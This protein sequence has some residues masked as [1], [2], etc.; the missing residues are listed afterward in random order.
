MTLFVSGKKSGQELL[1]TRLLV[2]TGQVL[3]G[4]PS[5][6]LFWG[7]GAL[8]SRLVMEFSSHSQTQQRKSR[9]KVDQTPHFW[10]RYFPPSSPTP[11]DPPTAQLFTGKGIQYLQQEPEYCDTRST[12]GWGGT[13]VLDQLPLVKLNNR[14]SVTFTGPGT[15]R[16]LSESSHSRPRVAPRLSTETKILVVQNRVGG[17][18]TCCHVRKRRPD[19]AVLH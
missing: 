18:P 8:V 13:S 3:G 2:S 16:N 14:C 10:Y 17:T 4:R 6:S 12:R 11:P 1:L 5:F 15:L 9:R 7:G 19:A